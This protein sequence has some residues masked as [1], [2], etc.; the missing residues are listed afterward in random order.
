MA[1][2]LSILAADLG[3]ESGRVMVGHFD[4]YHYRDAGHGPRAPGLPG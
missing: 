2:A 1:R 4:P 3:A